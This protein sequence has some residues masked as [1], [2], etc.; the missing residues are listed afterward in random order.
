MFRSEKVRAKSFG[1]FGATFCI[2][3]EG[4]TIEH[5]EDLSAKVSRKNSKEEYKHAEEVENCCSADGELDDV[6][7][8]S[9]GFCV[10]E[11]YELA[12]R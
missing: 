4:G 12:R 8:G 2:T 11:S 6:C 1:L 5:T 10:G 9:A 7:S 3:E